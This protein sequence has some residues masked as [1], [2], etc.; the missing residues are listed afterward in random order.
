MKKKKTQGEEMDNNLLSGL[1]G[2]LIGGILSFIGVTITSKKQIKNQNVIFERQLDEQNKLR[3][4]DEKDRVTKSAALLCAEMVNWILDSIR[5]YNIVYRSQNTFRPLEFNHKYRDYLQEIMKQIEYEDMERIIQFY[6]ITEKIHFNII[7][8]NYSKN[9]HETEIVHSYHLLMNLFL[10]TEKI[11]EYHSLDPNLI[12]KDAVI[13]DL[14]PEYRDLL[15]NLKLISEMNL[16][17]INI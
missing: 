13:L 10:T 2:A 6:G 3:E 15:K 16:N 9:T 14:K 1:I 11:A 7:N 8:N 4:A 5:F 12:T 17:I